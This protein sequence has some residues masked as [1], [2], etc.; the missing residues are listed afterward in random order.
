MLTRNGQRHLGNAQFTRL[1]DFGAFQQTH[2][3]YYPQNS[4]AEADIQRTPLSVDDHQ[5]A[6]MKVLRSLWQKINSK[7][8]KVVFR[9]VCTM[10]LAFFLYKSLSWSSV[11]AALAQVCP[12][13]LLVA[14]VVGGGGVILSAYQWRSLLRSEHICFDLAHL[15]N[16][17]IVGITF[18]HFLPTGMG[19]DTVKAL[20]VGQKASNT[21]GATS[22]VL[23]CRITGFIGMLLIAFPA[24]ALWHDFFSPV[25]LWWFVLFCVLGGLLLGAAIIVAL[26]LPRVDE[27]VWM[28]H[29]VL[30]PIV[31]VAHA[32]RVSIAKPRALAIAIAYGW[33][34]WLVAILN[35]YGYATAL[36]LNAP[37][38]FFCIIVPLVSLVSMLPFSINGFGLREHALIYA[39]ST[40]HVSASTSLLIALFLDVQAF[41]LALLGAWLY[42]AMDFRLGSL[43][44][45]AYS[46]RQA[47]TV[48]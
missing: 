41:C 20:Y 5:T 40:I 14:A 32:L 11:P 12:G 16:L 17:Y 48:E 8:V 4:V 46:G 24:L 21:A 29:R 2:A 3:L 19:G 15:V 37:L 35:C 30:L 6:R 39:F 7:W 27:R 42:F 45:S 26:L 18:N 1:R 33:V 13:M 36:G 31:R 9:A 34:F 47:S 44:K 10:V 38:H 28:R 23:M 22:A 43:I 25:I